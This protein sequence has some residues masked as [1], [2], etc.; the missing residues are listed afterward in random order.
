ME[1]HKAEIIG[2]YVQGYGSTYI[3][4][5]LNTYPNRILRALK[6]W[7]YDIREQSQAQKNA[8][9]N[10]TRKHPTEGRIRSQ[11]ERENI[12]KALK[13]SW[14]NRSDEDRQKASD[15]ARR[16][17]EALTEAQKK[18]MVTRMVPGRIESAKI[19]SKLERETAKLL[20]DKDIVTTLHTNIFGSEVDLFVINFGLAIEIDGISHYEPIHGEEKLE[21]IKMADGVKNAQVTNGGAAMLRVKATKNFAKVQAIRLAE[22]VSELCENVL[23]AKVYYFDLDAM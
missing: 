20:N 23:D 4:E 13:L 16:Q 14:D 19:G 2:Y 18:E 21:K 5:Q 10:G 8:L 22:Y 6:K 12:S 11:D 3:A 7:G 15:T 1:E 17:Y 9:K